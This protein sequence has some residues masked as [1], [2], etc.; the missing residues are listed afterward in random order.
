M[1]RVVLFFIENEKDIFF[2]TALFE[3]PKLSYFDILTN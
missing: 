1:Y 3:N 2:T